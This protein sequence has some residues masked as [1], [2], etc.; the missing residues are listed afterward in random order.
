MNLKKNDKNFKIKK[1]YRRLN[2][3]QLQKNTLNFLNW[4]RI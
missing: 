1:D 2:F 4:F 3:P